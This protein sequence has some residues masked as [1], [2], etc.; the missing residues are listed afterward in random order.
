MTARSLLVVGSVA[1]DDIDGPFGWQRDQLGGSASFISVAASYFTDK[2]AVVHM[3]A[4]R[5]EVTRE[6]N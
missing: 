6:N 1:V 2:A 3:R 4:A 5:S